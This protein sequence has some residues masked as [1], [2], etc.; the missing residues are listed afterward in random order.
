LPRHVT[1]TAG[2]RHVT[3]NTYAVHETRHHADYTVR[4]ITLTATADAAE[5]PPPHTHTIDCRRSGAPR[6]RHETSAGFITL[7]THTHTFTGSRHATPTHIHKYIE[8]TA[9][10]GKARWHV[11]VSHCR[12]VAAADSAARPP[13]PRDTLQMYTPSASQHIAGYEL[14]HDSHYVRPLITPRRP[15]DYQSHNV[16]HYTHTDDWATLPTSHTF[17]ACRRATSLPTSS[18]IRHCIP[19]C[20]TN[21]RDHVIYASV[22]RLD[23]SQW[24]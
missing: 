8:H 16:S 23:T 4:F 19:Q 12:Y 2:A 11:G 3:D 18:S 17:M 9:G 6:V 7:Y 24:F 22:C 14:R 15:V 10:R 20:H 1:F 5:P 21:R 13:L